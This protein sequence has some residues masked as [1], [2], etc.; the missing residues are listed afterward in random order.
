M[1]RLSGRRGLLWCRVKTAATG[2]ST[3]RLRHNGANGNNTCIVISL[4]KSRLTKELTSSSV[5]D[6]W[7]KSIVDL[8]IPSVLGMLH[9]KHFGTGLLRC[10]RILWISREFITTDNRD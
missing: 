6:F 7:D 1:L 9:L 8:I 10:Y 5:Y 3:V 4:A 2:T